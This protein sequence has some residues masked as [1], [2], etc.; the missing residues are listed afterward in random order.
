MPA[1]H[2]PEGEPAIAL[3]VVVVLYQQTVAQSRTVSTLDALLRNDPALA[4]RMHVLLYDNSPAAGPAPLLG[5]RFA[6]HAAEENRGLAD[7][8]NKALARAEAAGAAWLL[9]L[10]Q[11]TSLT[12]EFLA[13]LMHTIRQQE[14]AAEIGAIVP[15]L[16][17]QTGPCSPIPHF[18]DRLRTQFQPGRP[19]DDVTP[20]LHREPMGV[21]NSGA[22]VRVA[23]MRRVG[24]F[25]VEFWLD[26]LDHVVFHLLQRAGFAF[27]VL[28]ARLAHQLS[29][30][31]METAKESLSLKRLRNILVAESLFV[32]RYGGARESLLYRPYLGRLAYAYLRQYPD[33]RFALL[34]LRFALLGR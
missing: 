27:C 34:F 9:L 10:D 21:L 29:V 22:C 15:R 31:S 30:E 6:Y 26:Y 24:G 23:A 1:L 11:D 20:G 16:V 25:P 32:R 12:A 33:K 8:Y 19:F 3:Q 17:G 28:H 5:F 4:S 7:A 18:F 2:T 14:E 13:E